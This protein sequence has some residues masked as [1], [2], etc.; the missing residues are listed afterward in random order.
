MRWRWLPA[1][2]VLSIPG[3][4]SAQASLLPPAT[5]LTRN[6]NPHTSIMNPEYD[7]LFKLLLIGD[8]GTGKS[9]LLL[10]FAD[11]TY[12]ESYISSEWRSP[13]CS[14]RD[15]ALALRML[16]RAAAQS[17][18]GSA[19]TGRVLREVMRRVRDDRERV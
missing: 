3:V 11:D 1:E 2:R 9:C 6:L 18:S 7:Y 5:N 13:P 14:R 4:D 10:R 12:T 17:R 16:L 15:S 19:H 8:S